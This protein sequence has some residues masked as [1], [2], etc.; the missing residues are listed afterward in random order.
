MISIK[1]NSKLRA[2]DSPLRPLLVQAE[3]EVQSLDRLLRERPLIQAHRV[4]VFGLVSAMRAV[5][6]KAATFQVK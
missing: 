1:E 3:A 6:Q 5:L 2:I 4:R